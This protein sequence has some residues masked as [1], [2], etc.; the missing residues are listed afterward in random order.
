MFRLLLVLTDID[1]QHVAT[2]NMYH[3]I[4]IHSSG[5]DTDILRG[6]GELK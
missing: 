2:L 4:S 6:G 3:L 1:Q 5:V